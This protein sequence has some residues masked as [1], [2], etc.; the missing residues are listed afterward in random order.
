MEEGCKSR[1]NSRN[2]HHVL[3]SFTCNS[4][5]TI[6]IKAVVHWQAGQGQ[7]ILSSSCHPVQFCLHTAGRLVDV[8]ETHARDDNDDMGQGPVVPKFGSWDA[9]N[10]GYTVFFDKVRENKTAPTPAAAAAAPKAASPATHD[11]YEFDPYEHYENLSRNAAS[12]P[13]SSHGHGHGHG[14]APAPA[15]HHHRPPPLHQQQH[16]QHHRHYPASQRSGNGYHRRSGSN[17]S[18]AASEASSRGSKFSPPKPYQPRY[19]NNS[20]GGGYGYG[21]GAYAAPPQMHHHHH[22]HQH[23]AQPR[24]AASPPRHAPPPQVSRAAKAASAVPKFG[25]WDEQNAAAAG[26]GFT[27]QF[28]K[29]KRHREV[30]RADAAATGPDVTPRMSPAQA[31]PARHPRRKTKRRSFLSKVYRCMFPRVR[32]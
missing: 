22:H 12:R 30:A 8:K 31:A 3:V 5:V 24:V 20:G 7:H 18:S 15:H 21:A 14:H 27:V 32:E 10:I 26:Q 4:S 19:S 23:A 25:V 13:P 6:Y 16:Q 9:E 29:V 1:A 28:E 17:G 11:D 2:N